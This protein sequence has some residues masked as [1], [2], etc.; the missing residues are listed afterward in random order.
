MAEIGE[1]RSGDLVFR[2]QL[3]VLSRKFRACA[4]FSSTARFFVIFSTILN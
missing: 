4:G 3:K 1:P 2:H